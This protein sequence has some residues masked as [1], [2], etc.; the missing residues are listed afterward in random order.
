LLQARHIV[1]AI[2][3]SDEG[4]WMTCTDMLFSLL[5]LLLLLFLLVAAG[6]PPCCCC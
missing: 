4:Y 5:L 3:D 2:N 1:V 6:A